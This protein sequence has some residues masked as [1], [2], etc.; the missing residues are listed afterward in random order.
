MH[1]ALPDEDARD[2]FAG[3]S[4]AM[5]LTR[6]ADR[7]LEVGGGQLLGLCCVHVFASTV[8]SSWE[9]LIGFS[10][11]TRLESAFVW[12]SAQSVGSVEGTSVCVH[13]LDSLSQA[14]GIQVTYGQ[15]SLG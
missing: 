3:E 2:K 10:Q 14:D 9:E 15:H 13:C 7:Q 5:R 8:I 11:L 12:S 4:W 6:L 1:H